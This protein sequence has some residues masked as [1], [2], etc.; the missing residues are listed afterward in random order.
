MTTKKHIVFDID[1][2]LIYTP[3]IG[4]WYDD[5]LA[6]DEEKLTPE[7]IGR[8]HRIVIPTRSRE[9]RDVR[10]ISGTMELVFITRPDCIDLL[11]YCFNAFETVSVWSAG[12]SEYV[13]AIVDVVFRQVGQYPHIMWT[14]GELVKGIKPLSS[15]FSK[16]GTRPGMTLK[17]TLLIDDMVYNFEKHTDNGVLIPPYMPNPRSVN[18]LGMYDPTL[19]ELSNWFAT[20]EFITSTDVRTLD[21]KKIFSLSVYKEGVS[22]K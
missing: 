6:Y 7:L 11:K 9:S 20:R 19:K 5:I 1:Q 8:I 14:R 4:D 17:N 21:K 13:K 15:M 22:G 18:S 2:T 12:G 16:L 10:G 3:D